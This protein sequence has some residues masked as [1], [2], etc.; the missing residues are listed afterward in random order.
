MI[1]LILLGKGAVNTPKTIED[2]VLRG[3]L[4]E[5]I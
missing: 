5:V 4:P 1:G 3:V 2:G